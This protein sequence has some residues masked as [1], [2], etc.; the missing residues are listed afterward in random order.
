MI[1]LPRQARNKH[2]ES[3]QKRG[4]FSYRDLAL[5][6]YKPILMRSPL[7]RYLSKVWNT[8]FLSRLF[9]CVLKTI[10]LLRQARDTNMGEVEKN[11]V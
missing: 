7:F 2:R 10:I 6:L 11:R 9:K 5:D 8:P 1:N 3:T 4:A